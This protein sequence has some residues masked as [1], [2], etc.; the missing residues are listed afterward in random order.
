MLLQLQLLVLHYRSQYGLQNISFNLAICQLGAAFKLTTGR[1]LKS[2]SPTPVA[3]A[4]ALPAPPLP[5][6]ATAALHQY[7]ATKVLV[8]SKNCT[9]GPDKQLRKR[10]T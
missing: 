2:T 10:K 5:P 4:P 8:L 9:Q 6:L 7:S 3:V 1:Q